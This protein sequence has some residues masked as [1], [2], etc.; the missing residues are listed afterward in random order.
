MIKRLSYMKACLWKYNQ[1]YLYF[2]LY[3]IYIK[4][5]YKIIYDWLI[6]RLYKSHNDIS[7]KIIHSI[8]AYKSNS[9]IIIFNTTPFEMIR[10]A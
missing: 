10:Q 3:K 7:I 9:G 4:Y 6:K 1:Y 8:N 2:Y 5:L